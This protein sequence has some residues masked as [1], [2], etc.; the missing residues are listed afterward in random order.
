MVKFSYKPWREVVIHEIIEWKPDDLFALIAREMLESGVV[1]MIPSTNWA[2]GVVFE[3]SQFSETEDIVRDKL[4]G[5]VHYSS[6]EFARFPE[7]KP[8]VQVEVAGTF[9]RVRLNRADM[10]PVFVELA[11]FL[12]AWR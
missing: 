12:K 8:E 2:E 6:V 9:Y 3:I 1:G 11:T 10:N 5:I 7:Y 4:N